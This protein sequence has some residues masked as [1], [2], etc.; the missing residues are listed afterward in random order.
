MPCPFPGMDPY[1]EAPE[2]WP[3]LHDR[4]A[5]EISAALNATLPA[6]Y[7]ARLEMRPEIGI[8]DEGPALHRI[9]PDVAIVRPPRGPASGGVA[10]L[11]AAR[12]SISPSYDVEIAK[13]PIRHA[14][15]EVRDPTHG[16]R[17]VTLLE[18]V[19]P[20]NKRPGQDRKAYL[21]KQREVLDSDANLVELDLLRS[22]D[23]LVSPALS[24][25]L[26]AVDPLPDYLVLVNRVW[27]R[28]E[29]TTA[30]QIF[31]VVVTEPLPCIP[32][33]LRQNQM[34]VP[35]DLQFVFQ[36]AYD[37]G[38]YRRGA[39]DYGASPDPAL[40]DGLAAWADH[41]LQAAAVR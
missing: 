33:P 18:I 30:Y 2:I 35:L 5:T 34:E 11:E 39:V 41:C 38:P 23:R 3:D 17:L 37:S 13:E 4:L 36:R 29:E 6:P 15:V 21:R 26:D 31:P 8:V 28:L 20:S 7:Y 10:V 32:V 24:R 14:F 25:I 1:L 19:S 12:T 27:R 9:V 16:H 40:P 22:G